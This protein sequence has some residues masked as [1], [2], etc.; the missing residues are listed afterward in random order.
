MGR[1][2]DGTITVVRTLVLQMAAW[3][4]V[5]SRCVRDWMYRC[6][7]SNNMD[8][9][10]C[11]PTMPNIDSLTYT[12]DLT[13]LI[14]DILISLVNLTCLI[15]VHP[16]YECPGLGMARCRSILDARRMYYKY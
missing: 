10:T 11:R 13:H 12:K 6:L 5:Y 15:T 4:G 7:S 9:L 8:S 1:V 14:Y 2:V 3:G 16:G